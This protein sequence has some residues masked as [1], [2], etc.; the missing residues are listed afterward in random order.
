MVSRV[1]MWQGRLGCI[2]I[3]TV[4]PPTNPRNLLSDVAMRSGGGALGTQ[5]RTV[6]ASGDMVGLEDTQM[7]ANAQLSEFCLNAPTRLVRVVTPKFAGLSGEFRGKRLGGHRIERA[8][9]RYVCGGER[10]GLFV[11]LF[12][13]AVPVG[14]LARCRIDAAMALHDRLGGRDQAFVDASGN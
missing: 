12:P 5:R 3:C 14:L 9:A 8:L 11:E 4:T 10:C 1:K 7:L 6:R 13:A 2:L